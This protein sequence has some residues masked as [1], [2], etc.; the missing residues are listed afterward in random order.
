MCS[1]L[2]SLSGGVLLK[3]VSS[4]MVKVKVAQLCLTLCDPMDYTARGILQAR[5]LDWVAILFSRGC[6]QPR[7]RTQ[8]SLTWQVDSLPA[9]LPPGHK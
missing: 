2:V 1:I 5:I 8:V 9:E 6:S 4:T 7:D 3:T